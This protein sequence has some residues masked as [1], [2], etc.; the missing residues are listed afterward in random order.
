MTNLEKEQIDNYH[1]GKMNDAE[2][3]EFESQLD[4]DPTLKAESDF[5]ADIV[6]GLKEYRKKELKSRLDAIDVGPTWME[7]VGQSALM[8]SMG[9]VIVASIIGSSIYLFGDKGM[10]VEGTPIAVIEAPV[11]AEHSEY[12]WELGIEEDNSAHRE[13]EQ[14]IQPRMKAEQTKVGRVESET[15]SQVIIVDD[16]V[17]EAADEK[18]FTPSFEAPEVEDVAEGNEFEASGLDELPEES[19]SKERTTPIDV[20]TEYSKS[21]IIKYKYYDGKLFLN[22]DFD[23]AP[24]EIL[25]INSSTGRRIYVYYLETFYQVETTDKLIQLPPVKNPAVIEELK[26]LRENK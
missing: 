5:Q 22:G 20:K 25:E 6:S 19:S 14:P 12:V 3:A 4:A 2:R 9:G 10:Q 21:T 8:K 18:V 26:L 16:A 11:P 17:A 1:A 7:F 24:Y 23:K 15:P 13:L